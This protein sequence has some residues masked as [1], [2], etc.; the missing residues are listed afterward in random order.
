MVKLDLGALQK[1]NN[2]P[3]IDKESESTTNTVIENTSPKEENIETPSK[4][5]I[6]LSKLMGISET[7]ETSP[8]AEPEKIP[9]IKLEENVIAQEIINTT[10]SVKEI[11]LPKIEEATIIL[12][13]KQEEAIM[14]EEISEEIEEEKNNSESLFIQHEK[15]E[16]E[17]EIV[18]STGKEFFPN[19]DIGKEFNLFD[20]EDENKASSSI[21]NSIESE[22]T[23]PEIIDSTEEIIN[24]SPVEEIITDTKDIIETPEEK[25]NENN[26]ISLQEENIPTADENLI[27]AEDEEIID[28]NNSALT[29]TENS[30]KQEVLENE[31]LPGS[32]EY[33]N[34]VKTDLSAKRLMGGIKSIKKRVIFSTLGALIV[35]VGVFSI[36][37]ISD[38][39]K[40]NIAENNGNNID[41]QVIST[42]SGT[43][44]NY[45]EGVDYFI[46]TNRRANPKAKKAEPT[47]SGNTDEILSGA[48]TENGTIWEN[49]NTGIIENTGTVIPETK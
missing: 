10:P 45:V 42:S 12:T 44:N 39:G 8:V 36:F 23:S 49:T 48:T 46:S 38:F 19:F 47:N 3:I 21:T 31:P 32:A 26:V 41:N 34:K 28:L 6:S 5:K 22:N 37:N 29:G 13:E 35:G 2:T 27:K 43:N 16:K 25:I 24:I 11:L 17:D 4:P 7:T 1:M 20:D 40:V 15:E 33:V 9:E 30:L 18:N 14:E